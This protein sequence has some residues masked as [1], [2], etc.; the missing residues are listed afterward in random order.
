MK[1]IIY[2]SIVFFLLTSCLINDK[3]NSHT[4]INKANQT[5]DSIHKY[6]SLKTNNLMYETY[7]NNCNYETNYLVSENKA[8]KEIKYAYLWPYTGVLSAAIALYEA[9][10]DEKTY[11]YITKESLPGLEKYFDS[12]RT[13]SAYSSYIKE[14]EN[15][16]SDRFYDDNIWV[17][18]D[19][20]ALYLIT[21]EK[22]YLEKAQTIWRFLQSGTDD[23]L[24]GGIYWVEQNKSSKNACSNA[25]A[26]VFAL[27]LYECTNDIAYLNQ[28]I[29]LY[30]W[31]KSH[32]QDKEDKL[33]FDNIK[34]S[35]TV[36]S[37]K[38][39]Y[40]SGQMIQAASILYRLTSNE[41]YLQEAKEIAKSAYNF[42]FYIDNMQE[43]Q[44]ILKNTDIWFIAVMLRG[45]IEL[46]HQDKNTEYLISFKQNLDFAWEHMRDKKGLFHTDWTGSK[47][48]EKKW[49]LTQAGMVEMYARLSFF[50]N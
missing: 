19:F 8:N 18:L 10:Q 16:L 14:K 32:L 39:A 22:Y 37:T 1:N 43:R 46:Y 13:P 26:S 15:T 12:T 11:T 29:L 42:F 36:D 20:T 45:Y 7:P 9:N 33:I 17:G 3:N 5:L 40:N 31:T 34:L 44:R 6:Y 41:L 21:K 50:I 35:G 49:L 25:P 24:N 30:E 27:K 2:S 38:Y 47:K 28:A 4:Y 23:L 48:D